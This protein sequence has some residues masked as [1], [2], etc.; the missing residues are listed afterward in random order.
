MQ[1]EGYQYNQKR[2]YEL[3]E[4]FGWLDYRTATMK[5]LRRTFAKV[6]N[7]KGMTRYTSGTLCVIE[8]IEGNMP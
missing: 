5:A 3:S 2:F 4:H 7:D 1:L 6:K 8:K